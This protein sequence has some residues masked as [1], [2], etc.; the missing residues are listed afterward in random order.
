MNEVMRNFSIKYHA[1][2]NLYYLN[3][4]VIF[5]IDDVDCETP[6]DVF[7]VS[8][9]R[10]GDSIAIS[11]EELESFFDYQRTLDMVQQY[12]K[13]LNDQIMVLEGAEN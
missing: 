9:H 6:L 13:A 11:S 3:G 5:D 1:L 7:I 4:Y 8:A 10:Q 12:F 2:G